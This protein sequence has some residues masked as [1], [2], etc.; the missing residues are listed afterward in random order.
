METPY[1]KDSVKWN[2][3]EL[4]NLLID[5]CMYELL[6]YTGSQHNASSDFFA[7]L[8]SGTKPE[9]ISHRFDF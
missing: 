4:F 7:L 8:F 2:F 5:F 6:R 9:D 1:P 3:K